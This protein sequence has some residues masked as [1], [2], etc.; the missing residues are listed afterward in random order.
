MDGSVDA[1]ETRVC[2]L[3]REVEKWCEVFD[4][5]KA[6]YFR[7]VQKGG[8][9]VRELER[10]VEKWRDVYKTLTVPFTWTPGLLD[11]SR[12][13]GRVASCEW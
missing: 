3:E 8:A 12:V 9:E 5:K 11:D 2:E 13:V 7:L 6:E 10:E 1:L 4:A